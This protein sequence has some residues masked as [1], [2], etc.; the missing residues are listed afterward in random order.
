MTEQEVCIGNLGQQKVYLNWSDVKDICTNAVSEAYEQASEENKRLKHDVGNLGYKIKNQRQ[1]IN[2]R[3]KEIEKL[4]EVLKECGEYLMCIDRN[5]QL[6]EQVIELL[7]E[8][9]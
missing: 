1:E 2:N 8:V 6:V 7:G 9:K 4:K 3:L 5:P